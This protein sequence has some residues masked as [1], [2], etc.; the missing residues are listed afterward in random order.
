MPHS[1]CAIICD[2][3]RQN[4]I[5]SVGKNSGPL[6][7]RL[8]TKVHEIYRKRRRP[9][10]L[11]NALAR[12]SMSRFIQQLFAIKSRSRRET[13]QMYKFFGHQFFSGETTPT[14]L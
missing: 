2:G 7:S 5:V 8:W 9:F 13:E 4:D 12:L 10:V 6:L 14:F 11:S 1:G 3:L